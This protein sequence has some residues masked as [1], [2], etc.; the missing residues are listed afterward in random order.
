[1]AKEETSS[2]RER[3]LK[4]QRKISV[5]DHT[6]TNHFSSDVNNTLLDPVIEQAKNTATTCGCPNAFIDYRRRSCGFTTISNAAKY[7]PK[8]MRGTAAT[9]ITA[10]TANSTQ[11]KTR[12]SISVGIRPFGLTTTLTNREGVLATSLV[13]ATTVC[14]SAACNSF[15]SNN[16]SGANSHLFLKIMILI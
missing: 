15:S 3:V 4:R 14:N 9:S 10:V 12:R 16:D 13:T 6:I 11:R 2:I 7:S 5:F 8:R 1:M